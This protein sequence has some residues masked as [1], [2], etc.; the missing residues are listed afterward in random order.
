MVKLIQIT[1]SFI[2]V[3]LLSTCTNGFKLNAQ[4]ERGKSSMNK[5]IRSE[6]TPLDSESCGEIIEY[7][8]ETS[9]TKQNC[10]GYD[11]I[12]VVIYQT[13]GRYYVNIG[14]NKNE[15]LSFAFNHLGEKLEWRLRDDEPFAAIY[16]YYIDGASD[17]PIGSSVLAIQKIWG[18]AGECIAGV[19][20]GNLSNANELARRFADEKLA[21]FECGLDNR[22][23]ISSQK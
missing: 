18:S 7:D 22:E 12:P 4:L 21:D 2:I 14:G 13:D 1:I 17:K 16:R 8:D 11:N 15:G 5:A 9:D 20:D 6:Y 19:V 10:P 23:E 3:M